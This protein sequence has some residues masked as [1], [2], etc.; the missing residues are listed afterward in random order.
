M[1]KILNHICDKRFSDL[2]NCIML[3]SILKRVNKDLTCFNSIILKYAYDII[4]K[5]KNICEQKLI[6]INVLYT[7][8]IE[9]TLPKIYTELIP[10]S[11]LLVYDRLNT[12]K[13]GFDKLYDWFHN[14]NLGI[15][16]I[17]DN[18]YKFFR[19]CISFIAEHGSSGKY[20]VINYKINIHNGCNRRIFTSY[21]IPDMKS[22]LCMVKLWKTNKKGNKIEYKMYDLLARYFNKIKY[23]YVEFFPY[24]IM[25]HNFKAKLELQEQNCVLNTFSGFS[26]NYE[27]DFEING[28]NISLILSHIMTLCGDENEENL[29][30]IYEYFINWLAHIIQKPDIK[31]E[32]CI[33]IKSDQGVG[34]SIFF[35]WFGKSIINEDY[36]Y[37]TENIENITSKFNSETC[38]KILIVLEEAT[39]MYRKENINNALKNL[40]TR[41][42][43]IYEKKYKN[44]FEKEDYCNYVMLTNNENI[45][46]IEN[47]DRRYLCLN[48]SNE[49]IGDTDYF[50]KLV[51]LFSDKNTGKHFYHYLMNRDLSKF[52]LNNIPETKF[53]NQMQENNNLQLCLNTNIMCANTVED[54]IGA[55]LNTIELDTHN[56]SNR[57]VIEINEGRYPE[58]KLVCAYDNS[59]VKYTLDQYY[60]V[61]TPEELYGDYKDAMTRYAPKITP[62]NKIQYTQRLIEE[63]GFKVN[64]KCPSNLAK[65][66][67]NSRRIKIIMI[68]RKKL[69][70]VLNRQCNTDLSNETVITNGCEVYE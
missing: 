63:I 53:K 42:K 8:L 21:S 1:N 65:L 58:Y 41:N 36:Y 14:K 10:Y 32:K 35:E 52:E 57:H 38:D 33:I 66:L 54:Y 4:L 19:V 26:H 56:H 50:T 44:S 62:M 43:G 40:I 23:Q 17:K 30:N 27:E 47:S 6:S 39:N 67:Y 31:T 16:A 60:Y 48:A 45:V 15:K 68:E 59:N 55:L 22:K 11:E 46:K 20:Y 51:A 61:G 25:S 24:S 37:T 13:I 34:K 5:N 70:D 12:N 7:W 18:L 3:V 2:N 64:E 29:H 69:F 9:D 49:N 28:C